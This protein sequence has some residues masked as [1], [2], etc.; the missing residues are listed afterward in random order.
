[1]LLAAYIVDENMVSLKKQ[2]SNSSLAEE[3]SC[4]IS[5]DPDVSSILEV[6][7][8]FEGMGLS[9]ALP[10]DLRRNPGSQKNSETRY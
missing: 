5:W 7:D 2:S 1:M 10:V 3:P 4:M 8:Y 9:P 6:E